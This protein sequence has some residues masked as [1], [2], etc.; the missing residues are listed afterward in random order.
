MM[1]VVQL[2]VVLREQSLNTTFFV[3]KMKIENSADQIEGE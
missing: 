1:E 2:R 3:E